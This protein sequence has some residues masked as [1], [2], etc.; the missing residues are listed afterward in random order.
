MTGQRI[1]LLEVRTGT[2]K[3]L[4]NG[5]V[6]SAIDKLPRQ[7]PV[8]LGPTGFEGDQQ[9]DTENHGGPDKAVLHYAA[10]HYD[11]W[12]V[13]FPDLSETLQPG[14]FGENLVSRG[15]DETGVCIGDRVRIGDVL[16]QVSQ[17]RGPCYKLGIRFDEPTMA[18]R[19]EET[20]RTGWYYRVL[21]PGAITAGDLCEIVDRPHPEWPIR[22][23]QHFLYDKPVDPDA[24]ATLSNLTALAPSLRA[25]FA[26]R[27]QVGRAEDPDERRS[28]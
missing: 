18:R 1:E 26:R 15:I 24:L 4:G 14:G 13:E 25:T 27:L 20:G 23:V 17:P 28:A 11:K 10:E 16:V 12:A 21:E 6:L 3:P 19:A 7:G 2:V 9:A 22:R 8:W 5:E